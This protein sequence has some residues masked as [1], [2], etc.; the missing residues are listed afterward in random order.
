PGDLV[1]ADRHGAVVIPHD[2]ARD[3]ARGADL[4]A[5][6]E[7]IILNAARSPGF[8]VDALERAMDE[9]SQLKE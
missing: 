1:H 8:T 3:I 6:R 7:K 4:I 5:R 9:V 2:L